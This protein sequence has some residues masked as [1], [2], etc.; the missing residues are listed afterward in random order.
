[1]TTKKP[2]GQT[3]FSTSTQPS[4]WTGKRVLFIVMGTLI[5]LCVVYIVAVALIIP[6]KRHPQQLLVF[7]E[8]GRAVGQLY[9]PTYISLDGQRNIYI[10]DWNDGRINVFDGNGKYL[11][12]INLGSGTNV[13]GLAVAPDGTIY[14][15]YDAVI[16][17]LDATGHDTILSHT[18]AK[19]DLFSISI[20]GG[21]DGMTMDSENNLYV[22]G[23][24]PTQVIKLAALKP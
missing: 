19:G 15:S 14:V 10:A 8:K 23:A 18:N 9:H 7:G 3:S 22:I 12:V 11:R 5:S 20:S 6:P 21:V 16:H 4:G 17:K 2:N 1:M 13:L 24:Y